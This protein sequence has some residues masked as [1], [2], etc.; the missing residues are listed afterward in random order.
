MTVGNNKYKLYAASPR[1]IPA[2]IRF[3]FW[4]PTRKFLFIYTDREMEDGFVEVTP[5]LQKD[6]TIQERIWYQNCVF[7]VNSEIMKEH[8]NDLTYA[9][10]AF[11]DVFEKELKVE[12]ENV[13]RK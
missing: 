4:E 3:S 8:K 11:L 13:A 2:D 6:M 10:S 5:E 12:T 7:K 9:F 1:E